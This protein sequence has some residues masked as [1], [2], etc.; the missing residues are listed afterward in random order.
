VWRPTT[1]F[2]IRRRLGLPF[3]TVAVQAIPDR[4]HAPLWIEENQL[5][6]RNLSDDQRAAI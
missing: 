5:G 3:E 6:R 1:A 4:K 2:D